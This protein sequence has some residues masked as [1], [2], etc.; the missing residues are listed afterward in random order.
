MKCSCCHAAMA[1]ETCDMEK[2]YFCINLTKTFLRLLM[3]QKQTRFDL[4]LSQIAGKRRS[5]LRK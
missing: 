5:L 4:A 3:M 2:L 1:E